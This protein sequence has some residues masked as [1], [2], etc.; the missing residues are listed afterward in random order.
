MCIQLNQTNKALIRAAPVVRYTVHICTFAVQPSIFTISV[1]KLKQKSQLLSVYSRLTRPTLWSWFK[2][3]SNHKQKL[4][5]THS[6]R[7]NQLNR[8]NCFNWRYFAACL[9]IVALN[10]TNQM[11]SN[12]KKTI[13]KLL[14]TTNCKNKYYD[15]KNNSSLNSWN[16]IVLISD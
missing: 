14:L 7:D 2:S 12:K 10:E 4:Q 5:R 6:M 1:S 9:A 16:S 11:Q 15:R 8:A 13:C 3:L